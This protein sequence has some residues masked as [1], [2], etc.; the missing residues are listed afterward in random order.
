[1]TTSSGARR[2]V[3]DDVATANGSSRSTMPAASASRRSLE[4]LRRR[5][6]PA[7]PGRSRRRPRAARGPSPAARAISGSPTSIS[8]STASCSYVP[9]QGEL[10]AAL[11]AVQERQRSGPRSARGAPRRRRAPRRRP[12]TASGTTAASAATASSTVSWATGRPAARADGRR[13]TSLT[14]AATRPCTI[15][16]TRPD[17]PEPGQTLRKSGVGLTRP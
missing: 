7:A 2:R 3:V 10:D 13:G 8:R 1:M 14:I 4:G 9:L 5:A 16:D 17:G 15:V 6:R 12:G 11:Q